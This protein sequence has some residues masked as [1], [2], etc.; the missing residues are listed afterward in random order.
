M[1]TMSLRKGLRKAKTP[2]PIIV[3]GR[4]VLGVG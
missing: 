1:E 3:M 2:L 4:G